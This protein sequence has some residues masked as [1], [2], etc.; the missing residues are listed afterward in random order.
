M[1]MREP[2]VGGVGWGRRKG[3]R[4]RGTEGGRER[5]T[6]KVDKREKTCGWHVPNPL[7]TNPADRNGG[8]TYT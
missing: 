7:R 4:G 6:Q 2:E 1:H 5:E 8:Q 3:K